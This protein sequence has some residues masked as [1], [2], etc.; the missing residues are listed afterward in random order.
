MEKRKGGL[1]KGLGSLI[2][3]AIKEPTVQQVVVSAIQELPLAD[4]RPNPHQPRKEFDEETLGELAAS[5]KSIG[6]VQPI[7]VREV[8]DGKYE[9]VAGERR[10]RASKM[11]G[12]ET[13]PA[14]IRKTENDDVLA[15]ALIENI[16]RDDLNAMEVAISY[17]RLIDECNLTQEGLSERVGKKRATI[18]N[19][20]RLLKLPAE[21]QLA[22]RNKQ[23]TMGHARA[24]LGLDD[25]ET[26]LMIFEQILKYDFSV[27]KVEEVVRELANPEKKE[28]PVEQKDSKRVKK[29]ELGDYIELQKHLSTRF[30]TKVELK[31]NEN[32][33]GKIVI[34]FKS[35]SEL[36]RIMELL[37]K[38][39]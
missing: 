15:L 11:A 20:L 2:P 21:I 23:I 10:Y 26:Q 39:E 28:E 33:R 6:I 18:A 9:I 30:N 27:R 24:L 37:D 3:D 7:T 35:D 13:I 19:Y 12:R 32:G 1:G 38:I 25:P 22:L 5:I 29:D 34:A 17:Q 16:Q 14:Y 4:I 31:R 8:E 36:E